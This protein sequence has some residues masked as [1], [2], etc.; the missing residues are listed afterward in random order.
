MLKFYITLKI[1]LAYNVRV[2]ILA[3]IIIMA[4]LVV[5][6]KK[7]KKDRRLKMESFMLSLTSPN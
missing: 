6:K 1:M 7:K 2:Q 4:A 5:L 3:V